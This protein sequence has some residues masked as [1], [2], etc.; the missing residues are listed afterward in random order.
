M[1]RTVAKNLGLVPT[2][3]VVQVSNLAPGIHT[4]EVPWLLPRPGRQLPPKTWQKTQAGTVVV[5]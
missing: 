2:A 1:L 3:W 5:P 4:V